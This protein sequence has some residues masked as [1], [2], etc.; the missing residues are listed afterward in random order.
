MN[1]FLVNTI[2]YD[3]KEASDRREL[4]DILMKLRNEKLKENKLSLTEFVKRFEVDP[5][6]ALSH[7]LVEKIKPIHVKRI[8][9][10][11]ATPEQIYELH[12]EYPEMHLFGLL[13]RL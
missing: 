11:I 10:Y 3:C 5:V 12:T 1:D 6:G 7:L 8:N 9:E 2:G 4:G 13:N